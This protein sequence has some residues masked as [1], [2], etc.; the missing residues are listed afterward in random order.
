MSI[1]TWAVVV[2]T[3]TGPI[4]AV[5]ISIWLEKR[6][7]S[8]QRKHW[9]FS[10]LMGLRGATLN[11]EHVR[12]LNVVQVEFCDKPKV[13]E[14]W[15]AFVDHLGTPPDPTKPADWDIKH[16]DLLSGL[17]IA[18]ARSLDIDADATEITRGGYAPQGWIDRE[19][20]ESVVLQAKEEI[21]KFVLSEHFH[22]VLSSFSDPEI[23]EQ[24]DRILK[25]RKERKSATASHRE[26][27]KALG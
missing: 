20:K 16:R 19:Q 12:A 5:L 9:V 13:I 24:F 23:R 25:E 3:A 27:E 4:A 22:I 14:K 10:V 2:A 11:P 1:D 6:R 21:A 17:L 15:R 26:D 7:A 8:R 18:M